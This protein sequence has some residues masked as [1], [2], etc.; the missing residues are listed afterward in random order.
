MISVRLVC[1]VSFHLSHHLEKEK[2]FQKKKEIKVE[3]SAIGSVLLI[4]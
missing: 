3:R 4:I 2:K 1:L